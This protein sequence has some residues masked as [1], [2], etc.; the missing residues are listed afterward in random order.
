MSGVIQPPVDPPP[1]GADT[2]IADVMRLVDRVIL[3]GAGNDRIRDDILGALD[4]KSWPAD[5]IR[6]VML[7]L[8]FNAPSEDREWMAEVARDELGE[9][10][11]F[12]AERAA[13]ASGEI[14]ETDISLMYAV[15]DVVSSHSCYH[16]I[17]EVFRELSAP[18]RRELHSILDRLQDLDANVADV[19]KRTVAQH[20]DY[21]QARAKLADELHTWAHRWG[22]DRSLVDAWILDH[23][24][25]LRVHTIQPATPPFNHPQDNE[26]RSEPAATA[27]PIST[28]EARP[29]IVASSAA[30]ASRSPSDEPAV[31]LGA[32]SERQEVMKAIAALNR[33]LER[34]ED[35]PANA[36]PEI[37][38]Q[39][40]DHLY[41]AR[42][43]LIRSLA[44]P[45]S[46]G[47]EV[48]EA[49]EHLRTTRCHSDDGEVRRTLEAGLLEQRW[50]ASDDKPGSFYVEPPNL[51]RI[52][53]D[54]TIEVKP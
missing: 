7:N 22:A 31:P 2:R 33:A 42:G 23:E 36:L 38:W 6:V 30:P 49:I 54:P 44:S 9:L 50:G 14:S 18:A 25:W 12:D 47:L 29:L 32:W 27:A 4:I 48:D 41:R 17:G 26:P 45:T 3:D 21:H 20:Y 10:A 53:I 1:P 8:L 40:C 34:I 24:T 46:R 43:E 35:Q 39:G 5:T 15:A 11:K 28:S 16:F 13:T 52:G 51:D 19:G 37:D